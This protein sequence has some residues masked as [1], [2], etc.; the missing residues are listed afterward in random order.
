MVIDG[1]GGGVGST[2]VTDSDGTDALPQPTAD[3]AL[4]VKV[5]AV[6][7]LSSVT[8]HDKPLVV[9]PCP[10]GEEITRYAVTAKVPG[11]RGGDQLTSADASPGDAVTFSGGPGG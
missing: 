2:G 8:T 11:D 9:Q 3:S 7:L 1:A 5:Y 4:T 6:P 10:P